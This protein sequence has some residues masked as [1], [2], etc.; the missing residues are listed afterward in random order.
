MSEQ[1][2]PA[3]QLLTLPGFND[4]T[5]DKDS[6]PVLPRPRRRRWL[7]GISILLL[8][9]VL[10]GVIFAVLRSRRGKLTYEYQKV[11]RSDFSLTVSATGPLQSGIYNLDFSGSGLISE[12]NVAVGQSVKKGQVLARLDKTSLQDAV[13][14]AQAAVLA[15]LTTLNDSQAIL[16]KTEGL[17]QANT[18]AAQT[19]LTNAQ[20][21]Y[22]KTLAESQDDIDSAMT[23]FSDAETTL[24]VT[25]QQAQANIASAQTTLNGDQTALTKTRVEAQANIAAAQTTLNNAQINLSKTQ[26]DANKSKAVAFDQEQQAIANCN[27]ETSPP[28]DCIQLAE[29]QYAQAVA[30]ANANVAAAQAQVTDAQK[31]LG[32]ARAQAGANIATAQAQVN[33][34]QMQL[35]QAQ[36]QALSDVTSAQNAINSALGQFYLAQVQGA[37]NNT[38]AQNAINTAQSQLSTSQAQGASNDTTAQTQVN[39]AQSQFSTAQVQL[40]TA[41]HNLD[42]TILRAPHDGLVTI[43][44]GTVGGTPGVPANSSATTA[45]PG[46]TFIQVVDI[47]SIQVQASIN[48]SDIGGVKVGQPAEFTVSAYG[49]QIFSG[50]VSAISPNGQTVSN[51]VTYPVLIDVDMSGLQGATLL[52]GMTASVT[53]ATTQR[54]NVLLIP[55]N[56]VDTARAAASTNSNGNVPQLITPNQANL[57]LEQARQMLQSLQNANVNVLQDNPIPAYVLE[58]SK[59]QFVAQ[60]V[61]LGLT[62]GTVYEVL[63]GLSEGETILVGVQSGG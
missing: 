62:D 59:G 9:I 40:Q 24:G 47:S 41:Q 57:A 18:D 10:G 56:A 5:E 30:Q 12:I 16:S 35:A 38:T 6:L 51:V 55:V 13:N 22:L 1:Q 42:N 43:I 49:Q 4:D 27:S 54:S 19:S 23:T 48:E 15:A 52:P 39:T 14:E 36:A 46:S 29:N 34:A 44:N 7:I 45:A 11:V 25:E 17:S 21:N 58:Q 28:P 32:L 3:D 63:S 33:S 37:A 2:K 53:I 31:Q 50:N 8:I 20:S 26:A 61:V 60:P